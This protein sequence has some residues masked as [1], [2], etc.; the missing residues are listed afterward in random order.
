MADKRIH[1][2]LKQIATNAGELFG[3]DENGRVWIYKA[4]NEDRKAFWTQLTAFAL[5]WV[6]DDS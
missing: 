5:M 4:A 3:L 2:I 6:P 1:L